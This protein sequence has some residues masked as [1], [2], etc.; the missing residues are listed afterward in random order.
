MKKKRTKVKCISLLEDGRYYLEITLTSSTGQRIYRRRTC[1]PGLTLDEAQ[2]ELVQFRTQQRIWLQQTDQG[3]AQVITVADYAERW[4]PI[5]APDLGASTTDRYIRD[6]SLHI[7]PVLGEK[8]VRSL[9]RIDVKAWVACVQDKRKADGELY[10]WETLEGWWRILRQLLQDARVDLSLDADPTERVRGPKRRPG[11]KREQETLSLEQLDALLEAVRQVAPNRYAEVL[12]LAY[13]GMRPGEMYALRVHHID[14]GRKRITIENAHW[15]GQESG[16]TKGVDPRVV[17]APAQLLDALAVHRRGLIA[18]QHPGLD[19]GLLFPSRNGTHRNSGSLS[20]VFKKACDEAGITIRVSAQ[21]LRRTF[22]TLMLEAAVD[23]AVLWSMIGHS[24][25]RLSR[26]YAGVSLEAKKEAVESVLVLPSP[27]KV[28]P[29][30]CTT[31][32]CTGEQEMTKPLVE[33][34]R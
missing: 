6:L 30:C 14:A 2:G 17:Y 15:R 7:L 10:S 11:R 26:R 28:A 13:T 8:R 1:P 19:T 25:E 22:N 16:Q 24:D 21:V 5:K 9:T 12:T 3:L 33:G 31:E 20:K 18:R 27:Q 29:E 34:L 32:Q 23:R 4:M